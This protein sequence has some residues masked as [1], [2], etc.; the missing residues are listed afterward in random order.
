ADLHAFG[1]GA[2]GTLYAGSDGGLSSSVNALSAAIADVKFTSKR[3]E[4][5]VSHLVYTVACAPESWPPSAQGFLLGGLQDNGTRLRSPNPG[6]PTTFDQVFGGDG[7]GVAVSQ[8][9]HDAGGAQVPDALLVSVPGGIFRSANGGFDFDRFVSGLAPL[10]FFV[11]LARDAAADDVF[12]NY[13]A[14]PT[15]RFYRRGPGGGPPWDGAG[16]PPPPRP[17]HGT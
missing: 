10:P 3:N 15:T 14:A 7:F 17:R 16:R 1:V 13:S 12:L 8:F 6:K 9:T 4:G 11:R 2:D 5:L